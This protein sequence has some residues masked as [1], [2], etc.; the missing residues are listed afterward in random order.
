MG[1]KKKNMNVP[2]KQDSGQISFRV[3]TLNQNN[4]GFTL[5]ELL[6]VMVITSLV[7]AMVG[8]FISMGTRSYNQASKEIKLQMMAQKVTNQLDDIVIEAYWVE[9]KE[10]SVDLTAYVIYA[11]S[12]ISV[13][14]FDRSKDEIYM[15]DGYVKSDIV[16]LTTLSYSRRE[17]LMSTNITHFTLTQNETTN[18]VNLSM[19]MINGSATYGAT[20]TIALRNQMKEP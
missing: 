4:K 14:F 17:N 7:I 19:K 16:N 5:V 3:S 9:Q 18:E 8:M 2:I 6:V 13:I 10:L 1:S 20:H 11:S 15:K 12:N